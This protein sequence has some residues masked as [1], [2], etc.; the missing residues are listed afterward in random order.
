MRVARTYPEPIRDHGRSGP[1]EATPLAPPLP[2]GERSDR[3]AIRV[4]GDRACREIP[5]PSPQPSP[6]WGEGARRV[7]D[8]AFASCRRHAVRAGI[9]VALAGLIASPAAATSVEE[10]YR[11]KTLNLIIGYSVGGGYDLYARHLARH[12]VKYIPG[13]PTIVPQNMT[14]AG[15]LRAATYI[16]SVAPKDGTV[17]GT[18]GRTM[19]ITPLLTAGTQFDGTK[20]T[21]LG[22]VTNEVSTCVTWHTSPVKTWAD[23]LEKPV[24]LGGEGP[25]ADPDVYALLY[26]NV[27]GAKVKLVTGYHGTSNLTLAMERGETEG[28]CG[29]SWSTLKSRH[30]QWMKE[31]KINIII[32]AAFKKEPEIASVPLITEV[33]KDG[34]QMQILKLLLAA[35]E[36]ARPFAAPP[37]IPAD[38]KAALVAAFEQTMKDP[39]YL[40]EAQKLNLDVNPV[41]ARTID[42]LLAELYATPKDVLEKAAQAIAR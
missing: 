32:Q 4:R 8:G 31:N 38:R 6:R 22:S 18:F 25:G 13:R 41:G 26:K 30:M 2:S 40:S 17:F 21:W 27:F 39:E 1:Y 15:S 20:F 14:G 16:Y 36:M 3:E 23:M 9:T 29:L 24:T 28:L 11:G 5:S 42:G 34:E 19:A 35:Q 10:F 12:I 33:A 37:D 7:R